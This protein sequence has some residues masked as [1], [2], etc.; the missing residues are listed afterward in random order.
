MGVTVSGTVTYGKPLVA[1]LSNMPSVVV[2]F[3][4]AMI[5]KTY[6]TWLDVSKLLKA[7]PEHVKLIGDTVI[8]QGPV[9]IVSS[10]SPT[11]RLVIQCSFA[12]VTAGIHYLFCRYLFALR[13]YDH[14]ERGHLEARP[15]STRRILYF[16]LATF[17]SSAI[18][19]YIAGRLLPSQAGVYFFR[20]PPFYV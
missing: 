17:L 7:F 16:A 1:S 11:K 12:I 14:N 3:S 2:A 20:Q 18:G 8:F 13:K 9:A 4:Q 5:D 10:M 19:F 15:L 6:L